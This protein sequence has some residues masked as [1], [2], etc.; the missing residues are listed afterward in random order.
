MWLHRYTGLQT[1]AEVDGTVDVSY[2]EKLQARETLKL[3]QA[4][5][6]W[7]SVA[8]FLSLRH[9]GGCTEACWSTVWLLIS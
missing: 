9:A 4:V 8:L 2:L 3:S 6:F 1:T 5:T 7:I